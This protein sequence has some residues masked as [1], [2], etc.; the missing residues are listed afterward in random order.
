M[1]AALAVFRGCSNLFEG[2]QPRW[3]GA[4]IRAPRCRERRAGD[5]EFRLRLAANARRLTDAK[6]DLRGSGS[7]LAERPRAAGGSESSQPVQGAC[8]ADPGSVP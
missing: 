6:F 5:D 3:T 2:G 1:T 7:K 8:W 4:R